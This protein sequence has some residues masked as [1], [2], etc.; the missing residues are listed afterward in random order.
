MDIQWGYV[1]DLVLVPSFPRNVGQMKEGIGAA[2][3][4]IDGY[5]LQ[6]VWDELTF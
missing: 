2:M 6:R 4:T 3:S 1:E 5:M